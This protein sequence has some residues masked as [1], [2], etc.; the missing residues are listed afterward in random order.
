MLTEAQKA[1][2]NQDGYLRIESFFDAATRDRIS[3]FVEE[4][5]RW[6]VCP[7][8]WMMWFEKTAD[9]RKIISKAENFLDY[10]DALRE[11]LL[12]D[13][14][15]RTAVETLLDENTRMLKELLIFKYPDSGGYR[16]HQDIYHIP[17]KIPD[18]MVHAV[19]AIAIDDSDP[20]NGGLFFTPGH[21]KE[22]VFPMDAGGVINPEVAES[23]IWEPV[24]WKAGDVFIFDDYAPH[25]SLP[26]KSN[27][28]RRTLYLVFQRASTDGPT[29]AEY[30]RM[31]RAYNPPEG[32]L[33]DLDSL[34]VP[35]GIF[36]RD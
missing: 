30:N 20:D 36:Y 17:H 29:R 2:W 6:D 28:S 18:R 5:A 31:K 14:R 11:A 8:K 21:H 22:G 25:Y 9:S 35:N 12:A 33:P 15:I 24:S 16:P 34:K 10:H 26:N 13:S 23:F 7:D 3:N 27:R 4:V 19:A 1:K 32:K